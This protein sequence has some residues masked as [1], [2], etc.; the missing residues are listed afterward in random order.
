M[1]VA[2]F[3]GCETDS[4]SQAALSV[5]PNNKTINE[6]QSVALTANG[7][8]GEYRWALSSK[9]YGTLSQTRGQSVVYTA[10]QGGDVRQTITVYATSTSTNSTSALS[11]TAVILQRGGTASSGSTSSGSNSGT[12]GTSS[13]VTP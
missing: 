3:F 13:V 2:M 10:T 5:S 11:A 8:F 1:T 6:G 7:G 9:T 4:A 12:N